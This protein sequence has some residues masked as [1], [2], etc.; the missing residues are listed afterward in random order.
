MHRAHQC[1]VPSPP[2]GYCPCCTWGVDS[3][4][5]VFGK[6]Y[7]QQ[8]E[9]LIKPNAGDSWEIILLGRWCRAGERWS[10]YEYSNICAF[11][12]TLMLPKAKRI[13]YTVEGTVRLVCGSLLVQPVGSSYWN[14]ISPV[15]YMLYFLLPNW[16][17]LLMWAPA[18]WSGTWTS[19]T[20]TLKL[21]FY[22]DSCC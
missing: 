19:Q 1:W 11:I 13:G 6:C 2:G 21:S 10:L 18:S 17:T 8:E 15:S 20:C 7:L 14:V 9:T 4:W 5:D 3:G 22:E 12:T 16:W